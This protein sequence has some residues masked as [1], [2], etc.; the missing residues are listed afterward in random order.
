M[1]EQKRETVLKRHEEIVLED[2]ERKLL[3][4][5]R[6]EIYRERQALEKEAKVQTLRKI[7]TA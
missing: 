6:W 7:E 1:R 3:Y 4:Q 5:H 2:R